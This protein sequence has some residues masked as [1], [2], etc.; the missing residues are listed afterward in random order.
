MRTKI[1]TFVFAAFGFLL[2]FFVSTTSSW[3]LSIWSYFGLDEKTFSNFQGQGDFTYFMEAMPG[4]ADLYWGADPSDPGALSEHPSYFGGEEEQSWGDEVC[5]LDGAIH[6]FG[7]MYYGKGTI[8]DGTGL[9]SVDLHLDVEI[10]FNYWEPGEYGILD[11]SPFTVTI[12]ET[13]NDLSLIFPDV[14]PTCIFTFEE[15]KY[16][17]Q[18]IIDDDGGDIRYS[19]GFSAAPVPE[20]TTMLLL[21]SGL[22]GLAGFSRK[23]FK[24]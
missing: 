8:L 21:G 9:D 14:L 4:G 23:K 24:K 2:L 10:D 3:A 20:P 17:A 16:V 1:F 13:E 11:F 6:Y 19:I 5:N 18:L 12:N 7:V 15:I 22:V